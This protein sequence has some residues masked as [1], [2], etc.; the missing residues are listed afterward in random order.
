MGSP[1]PLVLTGLNFAPTG[2]LLV[3]RFGD[4]GLV[5]AEFVSLTEVRV[6]VPP[7]EIPRTV[8]VTVAADGA[9]FGTTD[10]VY[11][12]YDPYREPSVAGVSPSYGHYEYE[13]S[14]TITGENFA[15]TEALKA[16]WGLLGET[17]ATFVSSDAIRATTPLP[18]RHVSSLSVTVEATDTGHFEGDPPPQAALHATETVCGLDGSRGISHDLARSPRAPRSRRP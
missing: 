8:A 9:T 5:P 3:A 15:P 13:T 18:P 12:Y 17:D 10:A 6:L 11:T 16:R 4:V 7:S 14:V 2:E 1:D